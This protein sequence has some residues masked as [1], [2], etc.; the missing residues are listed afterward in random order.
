[1][2]AA[3]I[4]LVTHSGGASIRE[5]AG[6]SLLILILLAGCINWHLA[7][8]YTIAGIIR[9]E[10]SD[11]PVAGAEVAIIGESS[12]FRSGLICRAFFHN[13]AGF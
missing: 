13:T 5:P 4:Y 8:I 12:V 7:R 2:I 3:R 1:M 11:I 9:H 6:S 10:N